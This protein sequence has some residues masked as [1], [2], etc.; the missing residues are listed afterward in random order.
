M[1]FPDIDIDEIFR[2][3]R[4]G[5]RLEIMGTVHAYFNYPGC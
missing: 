1:L 3:T 5:E 4:L 2:V